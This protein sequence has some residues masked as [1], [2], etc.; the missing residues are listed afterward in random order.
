MRASLFALL[1]SLLAAPAIA[2]QLVVPDAP[3]LMLKTRQ[4]DDGRGAQFASTEVLYLK[5]ARQRRETWDG[6][7]RSGRLGWMFITQCDERRRLMV[8]T[9]AKTYAYT[10]IEDPAA[11]FERVRKSGRPV[12][13]AP[14]RAPT[15]TLEAPTLIVETIDTGERRPFGS[16]TARHVVSTR[17]MTAP[18]TTGFESQESVMDG[19]YIDVPDPN[20]W[21]GVELETMLSSGAVGA[22]PP[23]VERRGHGHRGYPIEET[24]RF[25]SGSYSHVMKRALVEVSEAPLDDALFTAPEDYSAALQTPYGPDM[26][27]PDTVLNRLSWYGNQMVLSVYRWFHPYPPGY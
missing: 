4:T 27:K 23:R 17:K 6:P 21:E 3:D 16:F 2:Q 5:G 18:T 20:C 11:H 1:A 12:A 13:P 22:L 26:S 19:W 24:S 9:E 8:N 7:A 15:L 14:Q 25:Q 10:P